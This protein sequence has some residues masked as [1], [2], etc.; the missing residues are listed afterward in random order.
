MSDS[1]LSHR[2]ILTWNGQAPITHTPTHLPTNQPTPITSIFCGE[3]ETVLKFL[4]LN[5][6]EWYNLTKMRK[7]LCIVNVILY[8]SI[9]SKNLHGHCLASINCILLIMWK[10]VKSR[11]RIIAFNFDL[12]WS[13]FIY[14][15]LKN[16]FGSVINVFVCFMLLQIFSY[17]A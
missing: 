8:S 10:I 4:H 3:V 13:Y 7:N 6:I 14:K 11:A 12:L 5:W 16:L 2:F 17:H 9:L 1:F 15:R